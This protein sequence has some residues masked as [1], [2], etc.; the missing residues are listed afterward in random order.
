M[1]EQHIDNCIAKALAGDSNIPPTTPN[2]HTGISP[3]MRLFLN[4]LLHGPA[5][6]RYLEAGCYFGGSACAAICNNPNVEAYLFENDSEQFDHTPILPVLIRNLAEHQCR[7]YN[8]IVRDFFQPLKGFFTGP[9]DVFFYDA[10]HTR[11]AQAKALPHALDSLADRFV[12]IVD[13]YN[14]P[15]VKQG[16]R[17]GF[18]AVENK[19]RVLQTWPLSGEKQE[20]DPIWHNGFLITL[21]EKT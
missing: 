15:H 3:T 11:L 16:T 10:V 5:P 18:T 13:D 4:L 1:T 6:V 21:C 14:W 19:I 7:G 8:L 9:I 20:L 12:F 2:L 17:E